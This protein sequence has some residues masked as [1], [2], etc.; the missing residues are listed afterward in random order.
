MLLMDIYAS[1]KWAVN[2]YLMLLKQLVFVRD[3]MTLQQSMGNAQY[4]FKKRSWVVSNTA[5]MVSCQLTLFHIH[6]LYEEQLP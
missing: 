4:L 2:S 1:E 5:S 3:V 6:N